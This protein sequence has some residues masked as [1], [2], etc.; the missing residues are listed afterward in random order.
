MG[1]QDCADGLAGYWHIRDISSEEKTRLSI[2]LEILTRPLLFFHDETTHLYTD[3]Y[4][5]TDTD[6]HTN[7]IW[8]YMWEMCSHT[9]IKLTGRPWHK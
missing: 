3:T 8:I 7:N 2:T 6:T 9:T 5:D 1:L 4:A